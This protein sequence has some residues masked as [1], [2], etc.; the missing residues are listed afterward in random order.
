MLGDSAAGL[1]TAAASATAGSKFW[2][3]QL[4]RLQGAKQQAEKAA[5]TVQ[6]MRG[7]VGTSGEE[8]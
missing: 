5:K 4:D 8:E 2:H 6:S 1:A 7:M 3:D